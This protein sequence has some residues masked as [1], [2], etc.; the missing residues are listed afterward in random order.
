MYISQFCRGILFGLWNLGHI[1]HIYIVGQYILD[2]N[3]ESIFCTFYIRLAI[4]ESIYNIYPYELSLLLYTECNNTSLH[5]LMLR[6]SD[7]FIRRNTL[8]TEFLRFH[9]NLKVII[10]LDHKQESLMFYI[11]LPYRNGYYKVRLVLDMAPTKYNTEF[12]HCS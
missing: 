4:S 8:Y 7:H 12:K 11:K 2:Y 5:A 3:K 10:L 1:A 6:V 9:Y